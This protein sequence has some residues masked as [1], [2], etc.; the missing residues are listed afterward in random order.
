M[1]E[2]HRKLYY[3]TKHQNYVQLILICIEDNS[4]RYWDRETEWITEFATSEEYKLKEMH[5]PITTVIIGNEHTS[6][7]HDTF[8]P[9]FQAPP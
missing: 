5:E 7:L 3:S 1:D 2:N 8:V 6:M 4:Y 9:A